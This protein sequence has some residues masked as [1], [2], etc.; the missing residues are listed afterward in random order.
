[1]GIKIFDFVRLRRVFT[2][3]Q[4]LPLPEWETERGVK[5]R[6]KEWPTWCRIKTTDFETN[7]TCIQIP[8][9]WLTSYVTLGVPLKWQWQCLKHR[10]FSTY[11]KLPT[12]IIFIFICLSW[13]RTWH[14]VRNFT[15]ISL[16]SILCTLVISTFSPRGDQIYSHFLQL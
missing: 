3:S 11:M 7:E 13:H 16:K 15:V 9:K 2:C 1:M 8:P 6:T 4:F 10:Y 14:T 12:S 5:R